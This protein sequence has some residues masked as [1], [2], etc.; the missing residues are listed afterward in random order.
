MWFLYRA[1]ERRGFYSY[2]C[3]FVINPMFYCVFTLIWGCY[4]YIRTHKCIWCSCFCLFMSSLPLF[5]T[6]DKTLTYC[7]TSALTYQTTRCHNAEA[8]N[9]N[10][11]AVNNLIPVQY[12]KRPERHCLLCFVLCYWR[13]ITAWMYSS[14]YSNGVL[15]KIKNIF[16]TS[17]TLP[18]DLW[19]KIK[20]NVWRRNY[21]FK[22]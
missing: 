15:K 10:N 9:I 5:C 20:L 18:K 8:Q 21:F 7:G 3:R 22:F 12:Y 6:A 4:I 1:I 11:T 19:T 14:H 16:K 2:F 17:A 13:I